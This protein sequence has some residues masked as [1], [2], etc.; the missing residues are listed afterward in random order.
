MRNDRTDHA[1]AFSSSVPG[2][3]VLNDDVN[4]YVALRFK[5]AVVDPGN[6]LGLELDN[7][8][9]CVRANDGDYEG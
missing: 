1:G 5:R 8:D 7:N 3:A 6:R 9:D 4:L 2:G